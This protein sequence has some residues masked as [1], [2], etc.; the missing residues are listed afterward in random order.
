M[1]HERITLHEERGGAEIHKSFYEWT[2]VTQV[3]HHWREVALKCP[4]LWTWLAFEE[5]IH[6]DFTDMIAERS[7]KFPLTVIFTINSQTMH[8]D[9]CLDMDGQYQYPHTACWMLNQKLPRV[10]EL[11]VFVDREVDRTFAVVDIWDPLVKAAPILEDLRIEAIDSTRYKRGTSDLA[12]LDVRDGLFDGKTPKLR[13]LALG[14]VGIRFANPLFCST[15]RTLKISDCQCWQPNAE[16]DFNAWLLVLKRLARLEVLEIDWSIP[17]ADAEIEYQPAPLPK[18][19]YL[20]LATTVA[21]FANHMKYVMLPRSTAVRFSCTDDNLLD[22]VQMSSLRDATSSLFQQ[23]SIYRVS[24]GTIY[25]ERHGPSN[26]Q[27]HQFPSCQLWATEGSETEPSYASLAS[28]RLPPEGAPPRLMFDSKI[29]TLNLVPLIFG[30]VDLLR[31]HTIHVADFTSGTEWA[32]VLKGAPNVTTLYAHGMAAFGLP[33]TLAGGI[34]NDAS[35]D[36]V[37]AAFNV[38]DTSAI[39][40]RADEDE[41][42]IMADAT[43]EVDPSPG[44]APLFPSLRTLK[45]VSLDFLMAA[46]AIPDVHHA[47]HKDR[48]ALEQRE[49][50]YGFNVEALVKSLRMRRAQGAADIAVDFVDGLCGDMAQLAPLIATVAEVKWDGKRV[51]PASHVS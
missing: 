23:M 35:L 41:D 11:V 18:L 15:L 36:P 22:E 43:S 17:S 10:R 14:G 19:K 9:V 47:T 5:H 48:V 34:P 12:E 39:L 38:A 20:H 33:S 6:S 1:Q 45:F 50:E 25:P 51:D 7:L 42:Q 37:R 46:N 49:D 2:N 26:S 13:S 31:V 44:S 27:L 3:C 4:H 8:C 21:A 29:D 28:S 30:A 40:P 16:P 24:Y 32:H